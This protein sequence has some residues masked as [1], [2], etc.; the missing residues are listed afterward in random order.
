MQMELNAKKKL[1]FVDGSL[2]ELSSS[3]TSHSIWIQCNDM[4]TSWILNSISI[5]LADSVLYMDSAAG[6]WKD[7]PER[8]SQ[9]NGPRIFQIQKAI[10]SLSRGQSTISS[11]FTKMKGLWEELANYQ[12]NPVCSC[13]AMKVLTTYQNRECIMQ[14]LMGLNESYSHIRGQILLNEPMPPINKVFSLVIQEERQ[15]G[16]TSLESSNADGSAFFA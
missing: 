14:F 1:A 2:L 7:L 3:S 12:P 8:F 15:H 4:V 16:I 5:D 9:G 11:Y 6:I 10:A 13:G